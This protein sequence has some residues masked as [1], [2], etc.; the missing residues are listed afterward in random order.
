MKTTSRPPDK[1]LVILDYRTDIKKDWPYGCHCESGTPINAI[2]IL[3][4]TLWFIICVKSYKYASLLTKNPL[5]LQI[6][7]YSIAPESSHIT[8]VTINNVL[9]LYDISSGTITQSFSPHGSKTEGV[10]I[11]HDGH[12]IVTASG[13]GEVKLWSTPR[14]NQG[15]Y[16]MAKH[17]EK[18]TC[19]GESNGPPKIACSSQSQN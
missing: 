1:N 3:Y 13:T 17:H 16:E 14:K 6:K 8:V 9:H 2:G 12:F 19:I 7:D 18:V 4:S 10:E 11:S 5:S 15:D